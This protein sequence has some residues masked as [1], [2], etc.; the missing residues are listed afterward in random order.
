MVSG[1]LPG[2]CWADADAVA[3]TSKASVSN[4]DASQASGLLILRMV[5]SLF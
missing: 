2:N 4:D 5:S 1:L 3:P